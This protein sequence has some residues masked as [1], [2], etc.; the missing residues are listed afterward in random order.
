[1]ELILIYG[2][3]AQQMQAQDLLLHLVQKQ[4]KITHLAAW[5]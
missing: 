4:V 2:K 5:L 1:M 3:V